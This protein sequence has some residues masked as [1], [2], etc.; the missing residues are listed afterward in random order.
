[1]YIQKNARRVWNDYLIDKVI[2]KVRVWQSTIDKCVFYKVKTINVLYTDDSILTG[3][4][5]NKIEKTIKEIEAT[6]FAITEEGDI[7]DFLGITY[8]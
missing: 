8:R 5:K 6:K 1:M 2:I 3:P 7:Q 4:K